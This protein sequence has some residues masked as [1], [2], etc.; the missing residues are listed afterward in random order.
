MLAT[1]LA[2]ALEDWFDVTLPHRGT[3]AQRVRL[4]LS[5]KSR[6]GMAAS[7]TD[8]MVLVGCDGRGFD[9][10]VGLDDPAAAGG[11]VSLAVDGHI[12][13]IMTRPGQHGAEL[14]QQMIQ[15]LRAQGCVLQLT[16][17]AHEGAYRARLN[18]LAVQPAPL[19]AERALA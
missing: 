11:V 2:G 13:R 12:E 3:G 19:A 10:E 14:V 18:V 4:Q 8:G 5:I 17:E 6:A 16:D 9:V 1:R 7:S 15:Q